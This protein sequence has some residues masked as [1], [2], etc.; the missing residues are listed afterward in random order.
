MLKEGTLCQNHFSQSWLPSVQSAF[1][2]YFWVHL[3]DRHPWPALYPHEPPHRNLQH[4]ACTQF[5]PP[6]PYTCLSVTGR[7]LHE[8]GTDT[9]RENQQYWF[10][11]DNGKEYAFSLEKNIKLLEDIGI[12]CTSGNHSREQGNRC[13]VPEIFSDMKN[14]PI[15]CRNFR[16]HPF[17]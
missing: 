11:S 15:N 10:A 6:D 2:V 4:L 9:L 8:T 3:R 5:L 1:S 7:K 16:I 13:H 14:S 17:R 12:G